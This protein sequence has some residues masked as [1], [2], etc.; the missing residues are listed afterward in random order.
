MALAMK[1]IQF[2]PENSTPEKVVVETDPPMDHETLEALRATFK[3]NDLDDLKIDVSSRGEL[4]FY[5][6][7]P[8]GPYWPIIKDCLA[9]AHKALLNKK[10]NESQKRTAWLERLSKESGVPLKKED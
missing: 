10:Q 4:L 9:V 5:K 6:P 2:L 7:I 3:E 8:S 1:I